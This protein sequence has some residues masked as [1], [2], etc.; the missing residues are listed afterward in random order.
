[1]IKMLIMIMNDEDADNDNYEAAN[2]IERTF[3]ITIIT[4]LPAAFTCFRLVSGY[5]GSG[6]RTLKVFCLKGS[7]GGGRRLLGTTDPA[8]DFFSLRS[9]FLFLLR[10]ATGTSGNSST[11]G[12]KSMCRQLQNRCRTK[13]SGTDSALELR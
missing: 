13:P 8:V 3:I 2:A 6:I 7:A 11:L 10:L 9:D 5:F 4:I 1:M 12:G